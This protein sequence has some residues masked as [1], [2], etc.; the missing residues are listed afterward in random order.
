MLLDNTWNHKIV[1]IT[2]F[3][4]VKTVGNGVWD[5]AGISERSDARCS[6]ELSA[7]ICY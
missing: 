3:E 7:P 6:L 1:E 4:G 5:E 2:L